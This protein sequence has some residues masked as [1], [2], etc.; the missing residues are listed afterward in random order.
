MR[1][2]RDTATLVSAFRSP[3]GASAFSPSHEGRGPPPSARPKGRCPIATPVRVAFRWRPQLSDPDDEM[4]LDC[5]VNGA[6]EAVVTM[7]RATFEAP[8]AQFGIQTLTPAA[9]L[10]MMRK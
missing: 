1:L 7:E 3:S 9:A 5:A 4:V 10:V 8:L 2:V 6:A